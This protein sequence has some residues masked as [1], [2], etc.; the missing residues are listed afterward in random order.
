MIKIDANER[1]TPVEQ[2]RMFNVDISEQMNPK[3]IRGD[4]KFLIRFKAHNDAAKKDPASVACKV[5]PKTHEIISGTPERIAN[6]NAHMERI[7]KEMET[8]G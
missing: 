1:F 5:N 6:L 2:C 7:K 4:N 3:D 8:N